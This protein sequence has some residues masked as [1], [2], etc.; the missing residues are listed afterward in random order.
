MV[1]NLYCYQCFFT[2]LF[3]HN[4]IFKYVMAQTSV[5]LYN[6]LMINFILSWIF[7]FIFFPEFGPNLNQSYK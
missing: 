2:E 4:F 6:Y 7:I 3:K 5:S 1:I